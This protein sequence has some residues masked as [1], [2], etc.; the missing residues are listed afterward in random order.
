M[1]DTA[2]GRQLCSRQWGPDRKGARREGKREVNLKEDM[3]ME[4]TD[5]VWNG[6]K[7]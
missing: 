3:S 6:C 4:G 7:N 1:V 2:E 5:E